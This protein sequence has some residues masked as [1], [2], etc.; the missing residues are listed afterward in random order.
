MCQLERLTDKADPPEVDVGRRTCVGDTWRMD[1]TEQ[2]LQWAE[3]H[4]E[5]LA[6][7]MRWV[8]TR[9]RFGGYWEATNHEA[10]DRIRARATAALDF[11]ERFAGAESRW[12]QAAHDVFASHGANQSLE[13]GA[14]AVGEVVREWARAVRSGQ[15]QPRLVESLGARAV[16][17]TDLLEQVRALNADKTV[18]PAAP[19]VL[20][21]AALEIA[22][23]SAVEEL[24]LTAPNKPGISAYAKVLRTADVLNRQDMKEV[25]Q[26]AGLRNQAA[27]GEH[28]DL[29][30]E[31]SGLMEQQVNI[32]LGK[33]DQAVQQRT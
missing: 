8:P 33:L 17:S 26:M 6:E 11:L 2:I 21:G 1:A 5:N 27:H 12:S 24:S 22:L 15:T 13:S 7:E 18:I 14:R 9:S 3:T 20:A 10:R 28:E 19:I 31:R 32:F 4:V 29:S 30:P 23:R 16:A 25:E